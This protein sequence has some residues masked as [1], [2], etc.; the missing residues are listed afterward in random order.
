MYST[1]VELHI[2]EHKQAAAGIALAYSQV[3]LAVSETNEYNTLE[4]QEILTV[5]RCVAKIRALG[6]WET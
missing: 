3:E 5:M 6:L 1:I 2:A 4:R